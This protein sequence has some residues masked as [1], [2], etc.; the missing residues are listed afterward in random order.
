M[1]LIYISF[2]RAKIQRLE[3]KPND[4]D[5]VFMDSADYLWPD[6]FY[7]LTVYSLSSIKTN[8]FVLHI[9]NRKQ[10]LH[11]KKEVT[12]NTSKTCCSM[13][14]LPQRSAPMRSAGTGQVSLYCRQTVEVQRLQLQKQNKQSVAAVVLPLAG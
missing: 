14:N 2:N 3:K 9:S 7:L 10:M 4:I 13:L 6:K 8:E 1:N 12:N 11:L 5:Q